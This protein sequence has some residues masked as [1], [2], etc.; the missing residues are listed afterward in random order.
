MNQP[1]SLFLKLEENTGLISANPHLNVGFVKKEI[2]NAHKFNELGFDFEED[3][4][5]SK[6]TDEEAKSIFEDI[7]KQ[8]AL[9]R[10]TTRNERG[11]IL[12]LLDKQNREVIERNNN[13]TSKQNHI[14][15][16][17]QKAPKPQRQTRRV[18]PKELELFGSK[19]I[20]KPGAVS[21]LYR[22]IYDLYQY[23]S[24]NKKYLSPSFPGIIRMSLR[25][26][27]ETAATD[28]NLGLDKYLRANFA[29]AKKALD[30]DL[31]TTLSNQNVNEGSITQLLQTGAHT[32]QASTNFDQT[33]AVSIIL[34]AILNITH[35][36]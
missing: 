35:G 6:H 11:Q 7:S 26:L 22:D 2:F 19:L 31:K 14:Q 23:Y 17:S 25:L 5:L 24:A 34:G 12:S 8:V 9:K 20:L 30:T 15:F 10:I 27:S 36:K 1:K 28:V 4:L 33:L 18:K 29:Q 32:Y 3:T 21:N 13:N 16:N